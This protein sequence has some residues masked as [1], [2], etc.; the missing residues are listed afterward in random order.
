VTFGIRS[1]AARPAGATGSNANRWF[2]PA[3]EDHTAATTYDNFEHYRATAT[4][5][6]KNRIPRS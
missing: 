5:M 3:V 1:I 2:R 4:L 6:L